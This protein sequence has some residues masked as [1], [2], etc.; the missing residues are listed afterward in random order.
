MPHLPTQVGACLPAVDLIKVH[1]LDAKLD[2][3]CLG[4]P[5]GG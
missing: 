3:A 1:G 5:E 2:H 4:I